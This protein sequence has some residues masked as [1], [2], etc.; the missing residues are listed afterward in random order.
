MYDAALVV[1]LKKKRI[2]QQSLSVFCLIKPKRLPGDDREDGGE[3]NHETSAL[4]PGS[5]ELSLNGLNNFFRQYKIK[6]LR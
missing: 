1:I 5:I 6:L 3:I 4:Q 2:K